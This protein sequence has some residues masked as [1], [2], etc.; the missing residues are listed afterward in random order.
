MAE[1]TRVPLFRVTK[2]NPDSA[3]LAAL[4]TVLLSAY[5]AGT[6]SENAA[7]RRTPVRPI[8]GRTAFR[9]PR[10]WRHRP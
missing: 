3:E 10:S 6:E 5:R 1:D 9:D 7:F 4:T 2:G 8:G